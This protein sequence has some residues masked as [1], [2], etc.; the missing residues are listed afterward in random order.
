VA[1][2]VRSVAPFARPLTRRQIMSRGALAVGA[3][4][5]GGVLAA[6]GDDDE[7]E[8]SSGG[9][10]GDGAA[11]LSGTITMM[12]YPGWM[13]ESEIKNF[14][15]EFPGV[16]VKEVAE[17]PGG[18]AATVNR[19]RQSP[20]I[21]DMM[22]GGLVTAGHMEAA[23]MVEPIDT[24]NIPNLENI[25]D[26]IR[27]AYTLGIPT[28]YGAVGYGYRKDLISE[29][30]T[31]WA[32]LW[33]LSEKYSGKIVF[34]GHDA[35]V[36]GVTLIHLGYS[37]NTQD[38]EELEEAGNTMIELKPHLLGMPAADVTKP[39]LRGE[40]V[41]TMGYDYDI[42]AAQQEN[43]DIVWVAPEE[44][45]H[46]YLDGWLAIK[47]TEVLDEIEAFMNFHLEPRI[48]ADFINT[49]G[50]AYLMPAA[51]RFIDESIKGNAALKFDEESLRSTQWSDFQGPEATEIRARI[52]EEIKAA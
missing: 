25:P 51:E 29:K 11:E 47:G 12:N 50:S 14:Q 5:L 34:L 15:R 26:F 2:K 42:A 7:P 3:V 41:I 36:L 38:P 23:E 33:D 32:E 43:E 21:Y 16:R 24:S 45:T 20:G 48:Y 30:P 22:L 4:S 35:E 9:G 40:A 44:G 17:L 6:C 18:T 39:M 37:N 46:A 31:T 27:E 10:D 49:T 8:A 19:A 13:G 52:W 1:P 28:D